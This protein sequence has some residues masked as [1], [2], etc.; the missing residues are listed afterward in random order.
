M[1]EKL[2]LVVR[3]F[4]WRMLLMRILMYTL[5]LLLVVILTPG[6]YFGERSFINVLLTAIAFGIVSAIIRPIIQF[7]T[8]PFIFATYGL[9]VVFI[10]VVILLVLNW[11]SGTILVV[12]GLLPAVIGGILI[13]VLGGAL[14]SVLGLTAPIV[15]DSEEELRQRIKFQD[16]SFAYRAFRAAPAE[17]QRY[18]PAAL[19]QGEPLPSSPDTQDAEAILATLDAAQHEEPPPDADEPPPEPPPARRRHIRKTA[20]PPEETE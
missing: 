3:Q 12:N 17:L 13:G 2:S 7:F 14:E 19:V 20:P 10:N 15:P 11:F 1:K 6:I 5:L 9:V 16:R 4:N 8:L 18:A